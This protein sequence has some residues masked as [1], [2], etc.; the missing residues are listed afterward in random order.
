MG[1]D[2]V[3]EG[4]TTAG[5][6]AAQESEP[7]GRTSVM[8]RNVPSDYTRD[9]LVAYLDSEGFAGQYRLIYLPTD[10]K[11][12]AVFGYAFV[13]LVS[14][15]EAQRFE[16]HFQQRA[17]WGIDSDRVCEITWSSL[18][19][20]WSHVE[21]YRNSPLMHESVAD[22]F[23]PAL[24]VKGRRVPFPAPTKKVKSPWRRKT[25]GQG[26][27]DSSNLIVD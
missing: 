15:D 5:F 17:G 24:Y 6:A 18:Q 20:L 7:E 16:A 25:M 4:C 11:T 3:A 10:F 26:A 13:D 23:K 14:A 27:I 12:Q 1:G 22:A 2:D 9:Q 19:G 8:M 21:R